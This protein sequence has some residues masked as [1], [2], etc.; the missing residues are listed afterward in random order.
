[1]KLLNQFII[2]DKDKWLQNSLSRFNTEMVWLVSGL[3]QVGLGSVYTV[4]PNS[5]SPAS[6]RNY[7]VKPYYCRPL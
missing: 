2:H 3:K 6:N 1:M 7:K 4:G 5:D